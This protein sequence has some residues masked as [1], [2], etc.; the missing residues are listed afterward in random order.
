MIEYYN[1]ALD[2]YFMTSVAVEIEALDSGRIAGWS[3]TQRH[4]AAHPPGTAGSSPVCRFYIPPG[5]GDSHFYS[6]SPAECARVSAAYPGFVEETT[7]LADLDL[8]DPVS[9]AC[10]STD[11]PVY[12][13]WNGRADSNHR[14]T[15]DRALRDVMVAGGG[16]AEGYGSDAVAMCA[17]VP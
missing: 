9:G 10:A 11:A 2:H 15:T 13:V 7:E 12:R 5:L 6:A 14:Y 3:R 8:P 4:F 17:P 1:R 16:I